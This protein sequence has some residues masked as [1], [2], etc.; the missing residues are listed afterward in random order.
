MKR[1]AP[2]ILFLIA[3]L[4]AGGFVSAANP[5]L[6]AHL[7]S[8]KKIWDRAPHNAF[9]DLIR[10]KNRWYCVF[11]EGEG[12]AKGEGKL[13]LLVSKDGEVWESAALVEEKGRD[14][15][16]AKFA[17][18]P[19]GRLM[20]NGGSA[21]PADR[22]PKGSFYSVVSFSKE[23]RAWD[24]LQKIN[25]KNPAENRCWLWRPVWHKGVAYGVA[26]QADSESPP[27]HRKFYAFV[28]RSRD[29]I[30][31]ERISEDVI[32]G[33]EAALEFDQNDILTI[34]LRGS[35]DQPK[36]LLMQSSAPYTDWMKKELTADVGGDQIGGPAILRLPAGKP[37]DKLDGELIGAGRRFSD[38]P[39]K[40]QRTG[41]FLIDAG[42]A[43]LTNLLIFPSGG[44]TSYPG[45][46]WHNNRLWMS[47]Y[48]S[49]E[50][51]SSIYLARIEL[52]RR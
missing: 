38:K 20:L 47:Y 24:P 5:A 39:S 46:V 27:N 44:D 13:R 1:I 33:T 34:A 41:L 48:S 2:R 35:S 49:H 50:G 18:T 23:G 6:S 7:L 17:I 32:G 10:F 45:L 19:D 43:T 21:D 9:T 26:Y 36:A 25:F 4:C 8:V 51:K 31:Y 37:V 40:E 42:Q 28:C 16:D 12:H 11:R 15:R 22:S 3:I 29:G 52:K 14:L 30:N